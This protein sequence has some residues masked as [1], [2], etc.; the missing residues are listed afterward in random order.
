MPIPSPVTSSRANL[1]LQERARGEH[2]ALVYRLLPS[3]ILATLGVASL[4]VWG[5]MGHVPY[6]WLYGWLASVIGVS[7]MRLWGLRAWRHSA[8]PAA[9]HWVRYFYL[10]AAS[11]GFTWGVAG[12]LLF[13][14]DTSAQLLI[15]FALAGMAAGGMSTLGILPGAYATFLLA[16]VLPFSARLFMQQSHDYTLMGL[17]SLVFIAFL[18]AASRRASTIFTE[19]QRLRFENEDMTE[20]MHALATTA[21]TDPLTGAYNRNMLNVALPSEIERARRHNAPLAIIMLDIDHF[22]EVNDL[23][24]HQVG[25]RTL[26]WLTERIGTQLRDADLLFRW[27]GEEF[28]VLAPNTDLAA[29]CVVADRMR[30]EIEQSPLEPAGMI[31]CSFG[32]SQFWQEDTTDTFIQRADRALYA[33]KDNGRNCVKRA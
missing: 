10:G 30:R 2:I 13:P 25:D 24:G 21:I 4:L 15:T 9:A 26:V 5:L 18:V 28:L 1:I 6:A 32:C 8:A 33:A 20:K 12:F 29:A 22:K 19:S 27:G 7:A 16:S 3:G 17:M 23:H 31:T 14:V 11:A